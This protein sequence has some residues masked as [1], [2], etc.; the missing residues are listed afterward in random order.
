MSRTNRFTKGFTLIEL[1][2]VIAIIGILSSIVLASLSTTR[3]KAKDTSAQ[4]S[5]SSVRTAAEVFYGGTGN[6]S[7]GA[8]G[9][10]TVSA[11]GAVSPAFTGACLDADVAKLVT[12]AAAQGGNPA[13]CSVG[14]SGATYVTF[15]RLQNNI[16][17]ET[18]CV[19]SNGFAGN[20]LT[21]GI[22]SAA[23]GAVKCR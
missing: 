5:L 3:S 13:T 21:T 11:T 10:G 17:T 22:V 19:D 7:Y 2:V 15:V 4:G 23:S 12:A 18:Y 9:L 1:L 8:P 16:A 20:T 14:I 6:G